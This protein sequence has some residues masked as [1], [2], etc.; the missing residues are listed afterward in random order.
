[1]ATLSQMP[2]DIIDIIMSYLPIRD[3]V[4][5]RSILKVPIIIKHEEMTLLWIK[6]ATITLKRKLE[7]MGWTQELFDCLKESGAVIAG[8]FPLQCLLG[9]FWEGSDIDI[10]SSYEGE[11]SNKQT[12]ILKAIFKM[13]PKAGSMLMLHGYDKRFKSYCIKCKKSI[14]NHFDTLPGETTVVVTSCDNLDWPTSEDIDI[15]SYISYLEEQNY[16]PILVIIYV[17]DMFNRIIYTNNIHL[18]HKYEEMIDL[19]KHKYPDHAGYLNVNVGPKDNINKITGLHH[20]MESYA[21]F[22]D[23]QFYIHDLSIGDVHHQIIVFEKKTPLETVNSFDYEFCKVYFD[24]ETLHVKNWLSILTRASGIGGNT[25]PSRKLKYESRGFTII[26]Y[27]D[28]DGDD[29]NLTHVLKEE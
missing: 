29:N 28:I 16:M 17:L 20:Y 10:F 3:Y 11:Y 8:S 5:L 26:D 15:N 6:S 25:N 23:E 22:S 14:M 7:E 9:E 13:K 12:K 24:G 2:T 1:M 4:N 27:N 21:N 19:L 18:N